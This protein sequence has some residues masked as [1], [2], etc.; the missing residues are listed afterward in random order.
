MT[1]RALLVGLDEYPDPINNL[2]SCV[3][4][5]Y[6]FRDV[7][8]RYEF[9]DSDVKLLHNRDATLATVQNGLDWLFDGAQ[10]GDR[11]VFYE[12]SH[13]YRYVKNGVM[14]EVLCLYDAFLE[15]TELSER[16]QNIPDGVLTV[17]LDACH[18]GGMDKIYVVDGMS[19]ITRTKVF[20]PSAEELRAKAFSVDSNALSTTPIKFFG[21]A[22]SDNAQ[23][24]WKNF[25]VDLALEGPAAK[26]F[27][28]PDVE[29]N[30]V[31]LTACRAD[32]TAA[33]GSDATDGL[34]AFTFAL[35]DQLDPSITANAL[36]DRTVSRLKA[37]GMTQ[38]PTIFAPSTQQFLLADTFI[39]E[40]P[41]T[42]STDW[43][44]ELFGNPPETTGATKSG[45][46]PTTAGYPPTRTKEHAA[47]ATTTPTLHST[48][49]SILGS[50]AENAGGAPGTAATTKP[51]LY[52]ADASMCAADLV[53]ACVAAA[54]RPGASKA[55]TTPAALNDPT[56]LGSKSFWDDAWQIA[57]D[58][59]RTAGPII[60][61]ALSKEY[62]SPQKASQAG[63]TLAA[64]IAP[65]R[66]HNKDFWSSAFSALETIVPHLIDV[67]AGKKAFGDGVALNVPPQYAQQKGWFD[68]VMSVVRVAAPIVL[69]AVV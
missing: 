62:A 53:P 28:V 5:T 52:W 29:I 67:A 4:D 64:Q 30:A 44:T 18:S 41:V 66:L 7:L 35:R 12:S 14:V 59:A 54:Q 8:G 43:W 13:G 10:A 19:R 25:T 47:M 34:S 68:D 17:V 55:L 22:V 42:G 39:A 31:L 33:A 32:E 51:P 58:V 11:R 26:E 36:C 1:N 60:V 3:K 63:Q 37:L 45:G 69:A 20:H 40:Q 27:P 48:I 49:E 61:D 23:Q 56:L 38:T 21:Q 50:I 16:T 24:L 46:F 57:Q 6:A 2:N 65:E 15:D 9:G